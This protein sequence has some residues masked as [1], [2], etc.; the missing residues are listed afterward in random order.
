MDDTPLLIRDFVADFQKSKWAARPFERALDISKARPEA[1]VPFINA[2]VTEL[3]EGGTFLDV[4][5]SFL[6]LEDFPQVVDHALAEFARNGQNEAAESVISYSSLQCLPAV[7]PRLPSIFT[8]GVNERSYYTNWPFREAGEE[9]LDFLRPIIE[10][11]G[12]GASIRIR[13]WEAVL[14]TRHPALLEYARTIYST[15]PLAHEPSVYFREVGYDLASART[16]ALYPETVYHLQFPAD[17]IDNSTRPAWLQTTFHPTWKMDTSA[18]V[19]LLFGGELRETALGGASCPSCGGVLHHLITLEPVPDGLG[20]TGLS[21]LTL[22]VCLSC[23]GWE[24]EGLFYRHDAAGQPEW[25]GI[26]GGTQTPQF[27][28]ASLMPT[29][30]HLVRTPARWRWQDWALSNSR[31]NLHRVGGNP[32]WIQSADYPVCPQCDMRMHFLMQLDS[33]LPTTDGREWLW[34][35]GGIGYTFWCDACKVSGHLWQCT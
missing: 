1:L 3:P 24:H 11:A 5:F 17:Y 22:A 29:K 28:A 4:L 15:L 16:Q 6:A 25:I 33:D 26:G 20:I 8:L 23:L 9:S 35:S 10:D 13:A 31:E 27:P 21:A 14:E 7:H 32:C 18:S 12:R 2:L 19:P 30:V 34:G